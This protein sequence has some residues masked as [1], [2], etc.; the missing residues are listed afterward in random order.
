[1]SAALVFQDPFLAAAYLAASS[2]RADF[3]P[4]TPVASGYP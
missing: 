1:V 4:T 2:S 3:F